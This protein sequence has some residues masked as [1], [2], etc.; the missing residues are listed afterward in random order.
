MI[1]MRVASHSLNPSPGPTES[2]PS[3]T[4]SEPGSMAQPQ[5]QRMDGSRFKG[6]MT[7]EKAFSRSYLTGDPA[8]P[9]F[10]FV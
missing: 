7:Q 6:R 5:E 4:A 10:Q 9:T 8:L 2:R 3:P 1:E